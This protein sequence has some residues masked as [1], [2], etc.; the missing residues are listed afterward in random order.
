MRFLLESKNKW[1]TFNKEDF[2]SVKYNWANLGYQLPGPGQIKYGKISVPCFDLKN[3][4]IKITED[5]Y[6]KFK[7]DVED[8]EESLM[9]TINVPQP[10]EEN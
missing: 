1:L 6:N 9:I 7:K 10:L 3:G 8:K 2:T 4:K 5:L